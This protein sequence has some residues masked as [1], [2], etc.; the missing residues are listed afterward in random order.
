MR[1]LF[2]ELR[3][4]AGLML[5]LLRGICRVA[6]VPVGLPGM[7]LLHNLWPSTMLLMTCLHSAR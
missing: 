3:S 5:L 2:W 4:A 1:A 7:Q 6:C